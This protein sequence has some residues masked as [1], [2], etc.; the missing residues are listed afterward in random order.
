VQ[1]L[2]ALDAPIAF[3][4][5]ADAVSSTATSDQAS[6]L[7]GDPI[8][9]GLVGDVSGPSPGS[10]WTSSVAWASTAPS[11]PRWAPPRAR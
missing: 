6:Y 11:S 1:T 4:S 9:L 8:F 7:V 5:T 3:A 10:G 2:V